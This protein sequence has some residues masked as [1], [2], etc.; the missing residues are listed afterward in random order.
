MTCQQ[1][2]HRD[3]MRWCGQR[4]FGEV[5]PGAVWSWACYYHYDRAARRKWLVRR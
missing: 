1:P 2:S 5:S 3:P 4:A